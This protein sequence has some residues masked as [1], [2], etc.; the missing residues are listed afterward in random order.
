M[1]YGDEFQTN[2][3]IVVTS[4][5]IKGESVPVYRNDEMPH[6]S[7]LR[8]LLEHLKD[9]NV[10]EGDEFGRSAFV[11]TIG[12]KSLTLVYDSVRQL[13][14]FFDIY[15]GDATWFGIVGTY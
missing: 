5:G 4:L 12:V 11:V 6:V 1:L 10:L 8:S 13:L 9:S 7:Y 14:G 3:T 15:D 2:C